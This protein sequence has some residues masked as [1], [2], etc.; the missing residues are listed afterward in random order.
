MIVLFEFAFV[1]CAVSLI[2]LTH[3]SVNVAHCNA[4]KI[5]H[6]HNHSSQFQM[7]FIK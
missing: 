4:I 5:A 1:L 2:N 6:N 7:V 3:Q